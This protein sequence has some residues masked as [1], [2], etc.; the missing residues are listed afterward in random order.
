MESTTATA[1]EAFRL[2]NALATKDIHIENNEAQDCF[3]EVMD[4][5]KCIAPERDTGS[6]V[7]PGSAR[8]PL[9]LRKDYGSRNENDLLRMSWTKLVRGER[10]N[11][12]MDGIDLIPAVKK[13]NHV[14]MGRSCRIF[15]SAL[16]KNSIPQADTSNNEPFK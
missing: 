15:E 1:V 11:Q 10:E 3:R 14:G 5:T 7:K 12:T 4:F 6:E 8:N 16:H 2:P 13:E 9:K